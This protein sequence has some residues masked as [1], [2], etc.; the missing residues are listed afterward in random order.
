MFGK[1]KIHVIGA[2]ENRLNV[3]KW[4]IPIPFSLPSLDNTRYPLRKRLIFD[5]KI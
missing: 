4:K 3:K 5:S 1:K 2:E